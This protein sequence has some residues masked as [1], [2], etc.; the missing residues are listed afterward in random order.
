MRNILV[1]DDNPEFVH[2]MVR[3]LSKYAEL[4]D[5][6]IIGF[7][8]GDKL[9]EFCRSNS[10]DVIYMDIE[11]GI[12][13][14]NGMSIA[15]ELKAINPKFLTV[16]ISAYECYYHDMVQAEP[17]RFVTKNYSDINDMEKQ[18][19]N[20]L[21]SAMNRLY[22]KDIWTYSFRR[23]Q[24]NVELSKIEYFRSIAR[25]I[26][27]VGEI[28]DIPHYFYG[29]LD[30][31][32]KEVTRI[33]ERFVRISKSIIVNKR[34]AARLGKTDVKV[35]DKIFSVTSKYRYVLE[36]HWVFTFR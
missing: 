21:K 35:G 22:P 27:I 29:K 20:T 13:K 9:L 11:L 6:S 30:K 4:Y 5:A 31:V 18:L 10:F 17:F 23:E 33:D 12:G 16:Y 36:D 24:Y 2:T 1:C 25:T 26:H 8:D 19:A 15:M 34:Y 14:E 28:G 3:M 32:E 7:S